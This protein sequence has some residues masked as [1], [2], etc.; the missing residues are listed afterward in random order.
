MIITLTHD[1]KSTKITTVVN[2]THH[3]LL[4]LFDTNIYRV[5]AHNNGSLVTEIYLERHE[6]HNLVYTDGVY[7][8]RFSIYVSQNKMCKVTID[9]S[10]SQT[11]YSNGKIKMIVDVSVGY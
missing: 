11:Y 6:H 7:S 4:I 8:W 10:I 9:N 2:N 3:G 1:H 5:K